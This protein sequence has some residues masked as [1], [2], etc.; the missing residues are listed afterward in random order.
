V[1]FQF[2]FMFALLRKR[3]RRFRQVFC[4]FAADLRLLG[5]QSWTNNLVFDRLLRGSWF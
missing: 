5:R 4:K 2:W 3:F 1:S